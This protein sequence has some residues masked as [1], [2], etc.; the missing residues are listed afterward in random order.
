MKSCVGNGCFLDYTFRDYVRIHL[1]LHIHIY[2]I[3]RVVSPPRIKVLTVYRVGMSI[4]V[5]HC[6]WHVVSISV[7]NSSIDV[8]MHVYM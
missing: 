2:H 1:C 3:V 7:I 6:S 5:T 8:L 4:S